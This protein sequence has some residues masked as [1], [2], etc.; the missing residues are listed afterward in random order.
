MS[1][2]LDAVRLARM[3]KVQRLCEAMCDEVRPM[4]IQW[5]GG[6]QNTC[7]GSTRATIEAFKILGIESWPLPVRVRAFSPDRSGEF[8]LGYVGGGLTG[9]DAWDGHLILEVSQCYILDITADQ[10]N[11]PG[12]NIASPPF[13]AVIRPEFVLEPGHSISIE[14]MDGGE[15]V[16]ELHDDDPAP[17]V[18]SSAW[19]IVDWPLVDRMV[20]RLRQIVPGV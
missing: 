14:R 16:M 3:K 6:A 18:E 1:E 7:I 13:H 5:H 4:I 11:E 19:Q 20:E 2:M 12:L 9:Y 17:W 15:T 8:R 10:I